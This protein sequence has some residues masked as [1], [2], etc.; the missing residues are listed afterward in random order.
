MAP[1]CQHVTLAWTS[2]RGEVKKVQPDQSV[3]GTSLV[4]MSWV[5][6]S[7]VYCIHSPYVTSLEAGGKWIKFHDL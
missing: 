7:W 2:A 1:Q 6:S 5:V 4:G 3:G